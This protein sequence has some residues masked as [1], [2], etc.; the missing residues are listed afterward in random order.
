MPAEESRCELVPT[1]ARRSRQGIAARTSARI[2]VACLCILK[3]RCPCVR[4]HE[5][6]R[7]GALRRLTV[8]YRRVLP[9]TARLSRIPRIHAELPHA[10]HRA[11]PAV[12]NT[13]L[14]F[15]RHNAAVSQALCQIL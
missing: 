2:R 9:R 4:V 5:R 1:A 14:R 7:A 12:A 11:L 13:G 15:P 8:P 3:T 6:L 10:V